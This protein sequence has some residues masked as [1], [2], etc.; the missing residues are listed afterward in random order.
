[1]NNHSEQILL[2][3]DSNMA[4]VIQEKTSIGTIAEIESNTQ[5][6][7]LP[8]LRRPQTETSQTPSRNNVTTGRS[9]ANGFHLP[10]T[11]SKRYF[12]SRRIDPKT[13]IQKPWLEKKDPRKKWQTILPLIGVL[14]GLGLC[15]LECYQGYTS[16][17]N[18][19]YCLIYDEDFSSGSLD[20]NIWT[21]EVSVG[22]F[23]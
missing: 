8:S 23:G 5:D 14:I 15:A 9:S 12:H 22:G 17:V 18:H 19:N 6:D 16:V 20:E 2:L 4:T 10:G 21:K 3:K 11:G 13:D 7:I 1:M